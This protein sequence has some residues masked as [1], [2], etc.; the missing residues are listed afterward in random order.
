M[1]ALGA[2]FSGTEEPLVRRCL[3]AWCDD[4]QEMRR[5]T[6]LVRWLVERW[7]LSQRR[8]VLQ[9]ALRSWHHRALLCWRPTWALDLQRDV[10]TLLREHHV[11]VQEDETSFADDSA[12]VAQQRSSVAARQIALP[13]VVLVTL[14][15]SVILHMLLLVCR[16]GTWSSVPL[17]KGIAN[18]GGAAILV[19]SDGDGVA[20]SADRCPFTPKDHNFRSTWQS[21]WDRDGCFDI[22]EDLDDDNDDIPDLQD[23]CPQTPFS[24]GAVDSGGCSVRQRQLLGGTDTK[25]SSHSSLNVGKLRDILLE[26]IVGGVLTAA[27][28]YAWRYGRVL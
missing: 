8:L 12:P 2:L 22:T 20:D 27:V 3:H 25:S 5:R 15:V 4:S 19:D 10:T 24:E 7:A 1:Q 13:T 23:R 17:L 21:D 28:N 11:V 18:P 14:I 9:A 26:V 6:V 16:T